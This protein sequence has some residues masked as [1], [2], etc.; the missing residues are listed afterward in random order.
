MSMDDVP[1]FRVTKRHVEIS[2]AD[3][4]PRGLTY[5][6]TV[7]KSISMLGDTVELYRST[8]QLV[9]LSGDLHI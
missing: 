6:L 7:T 3:R 4:Y 9:L 8:G 1:P 5:L 2:A